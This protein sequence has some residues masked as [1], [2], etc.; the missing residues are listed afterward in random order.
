LPRGAGTRAA[1]G[2]ASGCPGAPSPLRPITGVI[3][4]EPAGAALRWYCAESSV[5][6][7][8]V[9]HARG[10]IGGHL[11]ASRARFAAV[12]PECYRALMPLVRV[13]VA[14]PLTMPPD[15]WNGSG[16]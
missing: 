13:G 7:G 6:G 9:A 15:R 10:G 11:G 5:M 16:T 8:M 1:A 3:G 12:S 2:P 4:P 14:Q